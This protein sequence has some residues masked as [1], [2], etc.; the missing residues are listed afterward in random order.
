[1]P[2][3]FYQSVETKLGGY[4]AEFGRATGG[5]VNAVTKAGSNDFMAGIHVDWAPNFLRSRAADIYNSPNNQNPA[6]N[7]KYDKSDS[8]I[9]AIEASGPIIKDRLFVYGLLQL[10]N[11]D[12]L[13]NAPDAGVAYHRKNDDPFWGLKFDAFPIDSQHLEF[14]IFDTRNRETRYDLGY[15]LVD[16]K[17]VYGGAQSV[18]EYPTGGVNFVGKYTG[19]FTDWFSFSAAYGRVRDRSENY[20][21]A[22][23]TDRPLYYNDSGQ[24]IY[25]VADQGYYSQQTQGSLNDPHNTERKF[26][27][28]D[29]DLYFSLLGDHHI[30]AGYDQE[31][32]TLN[33]VTIRTGAPYLYEQGYLS[34]A[35]L[36]AQLGNAGYTLIQQTPLDGR[37]VVELN[38]FNTGGSFKAKNQAYYVEDEWKVFD[39]LTLNLGVRRDDFRVNKPSGLPL[40]DLKKNYAPRLGFTFDVG[41]ERNGTFFGSYGWYFLPIASN[42]AFRQGAPSYYITQHFYTAGINPQTGL[43]IL[44]G[45]VTTDP[46]FQTACP[47]SLTPGGPTSNCQVT[48][49]G[50]DIDISQA[51][52]SNLK[53]T[54]EDEIIV[55]YKHK[56][57]LW[58][59]GINYTRRKLD[60]ISEDSAV[61]A[62][63]IAY[64][65]ANNIVPTRLSDGAQVPCERI[66]TGYHQYVINNPGSDINVALLAN[67]YD[68]NNQQVTLSADELGYGKAKRTYD[69]VTF[70]FDRAWD[71]TFSLGG[72]YTWSKSKGNIEGFVQSDFGQTDAGITQDFDQPGFT[73][74]A[75]GYL[76]SDHR[77]VIKLFG[78]VA[79]DDHF[80]LG[81]NSIFQ[82]PGRLSCYGYHPTDRFARGYGAASHYCGGEPAPRGEGLKTDWYTRI[83]LQLSYNMNFADRNVRLRADVFNLFNSRAVQL[84]NQF[85]DS[86]RQIVNGQPVY[87]PDPTYGLPNSYQS[88]RYMRLGLDIQL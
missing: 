14:T 44:D 36:N 30:R 29:A 87:V 72:S 79:L 73:D 59:L 9:T 57:G 56:L 55:G 16:G 64:C 4:P 63:V 26:F 51:I 66:W 1:M 43:P 24:T 52:S 7:R 35:A 80:N 65:N 76:P 13:T 48:G 61:D 17:P 58:S 34:D 18:I 49:D 10:Q 3:Y 6:T 77:H 60:R 11:T 78:N 84:R 31:K 71:G 53:A 45:L 85:G 37:N 15:S 32:N 39:R 88:P 62:G 20:S 41:P 40:A 70:E 2:F 38:Y 12:T 86:A 19:T 69:A 67:G 21:I 54:R 74:Y 28:A 33:R 5:I 22:G 27:R 68:I 46:D 50:S 42:T 83:D 81:V 25:G 82:S 47:F 75:Y 23:A 8:L